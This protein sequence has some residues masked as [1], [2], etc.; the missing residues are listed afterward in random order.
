MNDLEKLLHY[1][2]GDALPEPGRALEVAPGV[3]WLRMS[4]PFVLNHINLW[5][6]R[7]EMDGPEGRVQGW[8]VVDCCINV[9]EARA[10]WE[11]IFE[12]E[13][14]GLPI[15]RVIVTHMHPDHIGLADWLC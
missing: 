6:L 11:Q 14:D 9:P 7:D 3:K 8:S 1:P 13:L 10:Q 5:L 4:L 12:N 2:L 15:L